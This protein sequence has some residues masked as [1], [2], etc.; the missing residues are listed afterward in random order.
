MWEPF[1]DLENWP[2][3]SYIYCDRCGLKN[4]SDTGW[5][6]NI[7]TDDSDFQKEKDKQE[8]ELKRLLIMSHTEVHLQRN[9]YMCNYCIVRHN[10][11]YAQ[12]EKL[13]IV[14]L[15]KHLKE[16]HESVDGTKDELILRLKEQVYR[17]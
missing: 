13:S 3:K 14:T 4:R 8:N 6:Y 10:L 12:I 5:W 1:V 16:I 7:K 17:E 9:E 2:E 11:K 15:K